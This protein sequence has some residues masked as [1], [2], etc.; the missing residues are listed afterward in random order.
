MEA[1]FRTVPSLRFILPDPRLL[2][3]RSAIFAEMSNEILM[4]AA[5]SAAPYPLRRLLHYSFTHILPTLIHV[6]AVQLVVDYHSFV[7]LC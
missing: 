5:P 6:R 7:D 3:C 4:T 1:S 2:P